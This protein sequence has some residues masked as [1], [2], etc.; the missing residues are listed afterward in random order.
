MSIMEYTNN[1]ISLII[2]KDSTTKLRAKI[3]KKFV[4]PN[5]DNN[6]AI[7]NSTIIK[8]RMKSQDLAN[9]KL[10]PISERLLN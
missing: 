1:E 4:V 10:V 6:Q 3:P 9:N 7:G 2:S 8:R 5:V